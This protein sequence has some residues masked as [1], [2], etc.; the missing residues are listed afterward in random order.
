MSGEVAKIEA[1]LANENFL[2]RAKEEAIEQKRERLDD[3]RLRFGTVTRAR[4][5]LN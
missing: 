4:E 3:A 1:E 5:R 2:K